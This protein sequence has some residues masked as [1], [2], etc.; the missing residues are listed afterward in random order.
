MREAPCDREKGC[1]AMEKVAGK[2]PLLWLPDLFNKPRA[3]LYVEQLLDLLWT[4][5]C[6][7]RNLG[8][9]SSMHANKLPNASASWKR[10]NCCMYNAFCSISTA[11]VEIL[12][13]FGF[14][15]LVLWSMGTDFCFGNPGKAPEVP[16]QLGSWFSSLDRINQSW[17]Y[18]N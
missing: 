2:H 5:G 13:S 6:A 7:F 12:G 4:C 1:Q 14:I 11:S 18:I 10:W 3:R 15:V 17:H 9:L 8:H 16:E